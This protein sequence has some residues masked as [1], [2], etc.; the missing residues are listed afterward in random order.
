MAR[1]KNSESGST[2]AVLLVDCYAGKIGTVVNLTAAEIASLVDNGQ[3]DDNAA[4]I[5]HAEG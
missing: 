4:A 1:T 2:K 5:A 3:A